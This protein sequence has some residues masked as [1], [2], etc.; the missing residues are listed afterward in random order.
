MAKIAL[1]IGVSEYG[2]GL[3]RLPG[4]QGDLQLMQRVLEN[5]QV[6]GFDQVQV[7]SNPDRTEMESAIETLLT[8]NRSADDLILLYFAGH[9]VRDDNG[10][11][12]FA[13]SI[14]ETNSEGRIRTSKAVPASAVQGYMSRSRS[15]RQILI[16]DCCFSGA[17]ANDMTARKAEVIPVDVNL[18]LGGEGRAVLTSSTHFAYEKDGTGI[19]TRYLVEGLET[20]AADRNGDG[21]ITVDELHEY[22]REK[23]RE[24][25]PSMQ[26]EIYAAREGYKIFI[27]RALQDDPRLTY[28]KEFDELAKRRQGSLSPANQRQLNHRRQ[29]LGL[30]HEEAQQIAKEVL[31]PY[32]EYRKEYRRRLGEFEQAIKETLEFDPQFSANS[33]DDLRGLQRALKLRDEDILPIL[34]FY[35]LDLDPPSSSDTTASARQPLQGKPTSLDAGDTAVREQQTRQTVPEDDLS[36]EKGID[37]TKLR[38]LLKGQDWYAA[39]EETYKAIIRAVGK[40][41]GNWLTSH[42]LLNFPCTDLKTIDQLWVKYSNGRFGFSIQKQIYVECGAKLDGKYPGD[43][44]W[45]KFCDCVGWRKD[46]KWLSYSDLNPCLSSPKGTSPLFSWG[47]FFDGGGGRLGWFCFFSRTETCGV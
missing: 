24:A 43:E 46:G 41:E 14:T 2:E 31:Q 13:T 18:Q 44:I 5:S 30:T 28:R 3:A 40:K 39:D 33:Q 1:L 16:L 34:D 35:S 11:L 42:E 36:S 23:V 45:Y 26:P 47:L 8:E 10:T 9:G 6:C 7:L 37:Y 22:A 32:R 38:D 12:Y 27:A 15:R 17:F 19:Y 4:T 25:A 20:G 29:E 21:Q